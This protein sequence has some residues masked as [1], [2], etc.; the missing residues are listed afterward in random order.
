M[1]STTNYKYISKD[2]T[3]KE[4]YSPDNPPPSD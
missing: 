3:T 4:V 2:G 1:L